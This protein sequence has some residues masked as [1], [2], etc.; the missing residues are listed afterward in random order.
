VDEDDVVAIL[1]KGIKAVDR[2]PIAHP[3]TGMMQPR[4]ALI[5]AFP[6][7]FRAAGPDADRGAAADA[8]Q[9][10]VAVE[11]H[12]ELEIADE[13]APESR[14]PREIAGGQDHMGDPVEIAGHLI[15]ARV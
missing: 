6:G 14:R 10:R 8:V 2:V 11:H 1:Q 7:I 15:A 3:E 13:V 12:L 4:R 5:E 9:H